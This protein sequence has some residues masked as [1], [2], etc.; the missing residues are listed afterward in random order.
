MPALK[1]LSPPQHLTFK[2]SLILLI[3]TDKAV[4]LFEWCLYRIVVH[5]LESK[6]YKEVKSLRACRQAI[7]V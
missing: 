1:R 5:N 4:L 6:T 2:K 7:E 3:K